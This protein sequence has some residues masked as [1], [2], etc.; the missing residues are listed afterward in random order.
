MCVCVCVCCAEGPAWPPMMIVAPQSNTAWINSKT[1]HIWTPL[2]FSVR[3]Q[4]MVLSWKYKQ[5]TN[6]RLDAQKEPLCLPCIYPASSFQPSSSRRMLLIWELTHEGPSS[7]LCGKTDPNMTNFLTCNLSPCLPEEMQEKEYNEK[8][9]TKR[10]KAK[11]QH[12]NRLT[13]LV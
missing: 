6:A 9:L 8:P 10:A 5:H 1:K 13:R 7:L 12:A 11:A 3:G 2:S 4:L